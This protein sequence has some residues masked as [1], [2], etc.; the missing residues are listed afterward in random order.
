MHAE[1]QSFDA[2]VVP[3]LPS[4]AK[5][6]PFL[7]FED[8]ETIEK[9]N[10]Q[11]FLFNNNE[12]MCTLNFNQCIETGSM[13]TPIKIKDKRPILLNA[14]EPK[15]TL[16]SLSDLSGENY[17][18]NI[19]HITP[20][21]DQ[22][23]VGF[24]QMTKQLSTIMETTETTNSTELHTKSIISSP[25]SDNDTETPVH[26]TKQMKTKNI[27]VK[28]ETVLDNKEAK[29]VSKNS[30]G[31]PLTFTIIE[32]KTEIMKE[33]PLKSPS[34]N[35][36]D[37]FKLLPEKSIILTKGAFSIFEDKTDNL[38]PIQLPTLDLV[39]DTE[40]VNKENIS[41]VM[42]TENLNLLK[43]MNK[44]PEFLAYYSDINNSY[45][46]TS[47]MNKNNLH[48]SMVASNKIQ[49]VSDV[50]KYLSIPN[51]N[52]KETS[53]IIKTVVLP[54]EE[55]TK[56]GSVVSENSILE[57]SLIEKTNVQSPFSLINKDN[58]KHILLSSSTEINAI[59]RISDQFYDSFCK[60]PV[61]IK[62]GHHLDKSPN[63]SCEEQGNSNNVLQTDLKSGGKLVSIK[64]SKSKSFRKPLN[65]MKGNSVDF[66][67]IFSKSPEKPGKLVNFGNDTSS[68]L[69]LDSTNTRDATQS[70]LKF[71]LD[72]TKSLSKIAEV[73]SLANGGSLIHESQIKQE[74]SLH[75]SNR[76]SA[77]A[78]P[79]SD[80]ATIPFKKPLFAEDDNINT[81]SFA[82]NLGRDQNSTFIAQPEF[83]IL[84][85]KNEDR[86]LAIE[87]SNTVIDTRL[88]VRLDE[89]EF[90]NE[91]PILLSEKNGSEL[92]EKKRNLEQTKRT[93]LSLS[94][95]KMQGKII[96]TEKSVD[97]TIDDLGV[98]IY[99]PA[100]SQI[101]DL[102]DEHWDEVNED[103]ELFAEAN[104]YLASMIDLDETRA[105]IHD[106][107]LEE[108][109]NPFDKAL[110]NALLDQIDFIS[111]LR[112]LKTC[113]LRNKICQLTKGKTL[114]FGNETFDIIKAIGK[115]A[116]GVVFT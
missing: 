31:P 28:T 103:Y 61:K 67:D 12:T 63:L 14:I 87:K 110:S 42:L 56:Q 108:I 98:S 96:P 22:E 85:E 57:M 24:S 9:A 68:L 2:F 16:D 34:F 39:N 99:V 100:S 32:E 1:D 3:K 80:L 17:Q 82:S 97:T 30:M 75:I 54:E 76:F 51:E 93:M 62:S 26:N 23:N 21:I 81:L 6:T 66:Y 94:K 115:G 38:K 49:N 5:Q 50:M 46:D 20:A 35:L 47:T 45:D 4:P 58:T 33:D 111:Y 64:V 69:K 7:V 25:E 29:I 27:I 41:H 10:N 106:Q 95:E 89:D 114:E 73:N 90:H 74:K 102:H 44:D 43:K 8:V 78:E 79:L 19:S 112:D 36:S 53:L 65:N 71:N 104:Q 86:L 88:R 70:L 59:N 13:S 105:F 84:T 83:K 52:S 101:E 91:I 77:F 37:E 113:S 40:I 107:L 11:W 60:S 55:V 72:D 92:I 48:N 18:Q 116:Y 15:Q 109:I